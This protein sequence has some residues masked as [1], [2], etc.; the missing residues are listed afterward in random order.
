MYS[1]SSPQISLAI[2]KENPIA[3]LTSRAFR[4][5]HDRREKR[6]HYVG[7]DDANSRLR[8]LRNEPARDPIRDIVERLDRLFD[9]L[10]G[11][12]VLLSRAH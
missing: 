1:R 8:L 12:R 5:P 10:P 6:V 9:P 3:G 2:A 7:V 11:L 4:P